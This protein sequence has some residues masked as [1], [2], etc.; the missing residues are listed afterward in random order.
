MNLYGDFYDITIVRQIKTPKV[1]MSIVSS[2][3]S[4]S[5]QLS[6]TSF[7]S[8]FLLYVDILLKYSLR[9]HP[10]SATTLD[11]SPTI[12]AKSPTVTSANLLLIPQLLP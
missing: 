1:G 4:Y 10:P 2:Q 6:P 8:H 3:Q 5:G 12:P 11:I 9:P 7:P